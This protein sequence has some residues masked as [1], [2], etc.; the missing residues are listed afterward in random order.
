MLQDAL[1]YMIVF[2]GLLAFQALLGWSGERRVIRD[3]DP[4]KLA[5]INLKA[6]MAVVIIVAV[7][8][9]LA[10][11]LAGSFFG[12]QPMMLFLAGAFSAIANETII[13]WR[14]ERRVRRMAAEAES[15]PS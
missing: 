14:R 10:A 13:E 15:Q 5:I 2:L 8:Y 4:K 12:G 1:P 11:L 9:G 6:T 7:I 3:S